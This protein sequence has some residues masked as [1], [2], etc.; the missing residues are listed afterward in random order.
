MKYIKILLTLFLLTGCIVS[1]EEKYGKQ[2]LPQSNNNKVSFIAVGDNIMHEQLIKEAKKDNTYDF[3]PYYSEVRQYIEKAD[4]AFVNQ[5]TIL[6]GKDKGYTGY[7]LFNTPD[8]MA[9]CLS[10]IGFDI[11][12]GGTNHA[13][14]QGESG[15]TH[16]LSVFKQYDN[17]TY[18]G[19]RQEDI[20]VVEKN[21]IRIAFLSYN[22]FINFEE[23]TDSLRQF[24]EDFIKQ[25]VENAKEISDVIIASCHYGIE[26]STKLGDKQQRYSQLLADLGVD[27]ILG[28]HSH[29][30]QPVKWIEGKEGNKTLVA[31]SLGN[32]ISG[33][34]D[35]ECQ[36]GGMLSFDIVEE[37]NS[38]SIENATLTPLMNH[39]KTKSIANIWE[40]RYDFKVYRLKDYTDALASEHGL[41][42]YEGIKIS[43]EKMKQKVKDR[44]QEGIHI[45]M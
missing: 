24:N 3:T 13:I 20:P 7:P 38:F 8:E 6:G 17:L 22:Q 30:L 32:F 35:E 4:L 29:T 37:N 34:L 16:S 44:V 23:E 10:D 43:L 14:D 11:V 42:G 12:N 25:D 36:L 15:I 18:I 45:D 1:E 9:K 31:Y 21:G 33:M 41:N 27:V 28:T 40:S 5:E 26:N 19:L 2:E 39:Y